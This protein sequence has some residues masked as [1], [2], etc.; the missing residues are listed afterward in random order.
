MTIGQ[1]IQKRVDALP[2]DKQKK[3]LSL[4]RKLA[5]SNGQHRRNGK[6]AARQVHDESY[7]PK[8]PALRA[9]AGLW[10]DRTDLPKD[11]VEAVKVIRA[12]MR[13]RGRRHV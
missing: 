8:D 6:P 13:S 7:I 1:I 3:V 12:R 11:P 2:P 9:F 5:A 4:V 10:K